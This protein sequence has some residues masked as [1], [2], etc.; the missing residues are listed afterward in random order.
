ML[1]LRQN[2]HRGGIPLGEPQADWKG[3]GF[4]SQLTWIP[5]RAGFRGRELPLLPLVKCSTWTAFVLIEEL[6]N[7]HIYRNQ[8]T[9][10]YF[11]LKITI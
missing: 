6:F 1:L 3:I 2:L 9:Y 11:N 4:S 10:W 7:D 5:D 8:S